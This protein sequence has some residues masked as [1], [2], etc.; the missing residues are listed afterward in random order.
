MPLKN[1]KGSRPAPVRD[2]GDDGGAL[3]IT[4]VFT[5]EE[6]TSEALK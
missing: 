4:V 6:G 3:N 2:Q 5:S 1:L